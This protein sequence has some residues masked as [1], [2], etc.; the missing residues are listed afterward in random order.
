MQNSQLQKILRLI[1]QTRDRVVVL[2]PVSDDVVVLLRLED[3]ENLR[4]VARPAPAS[5]PPDSLVLPEDL[6]PTDDDDDSQELPGDVRA[7]EQFTPP[8]ANPKTSWTIPASRLEFSADW[9]EHNA[10]SQSEELNNLSE[11][12]E[13]QFYPEP[14]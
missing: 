9:A 10:P 6:G 2:D 13:E 5:L 1:R 3:Y 7:E 12:P 14:V 8:A 11:E 4:G